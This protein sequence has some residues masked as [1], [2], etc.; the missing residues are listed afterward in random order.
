V[1]SLETF[2]Y[3]ALDALPSH[4]AILD[5][6]GNIVAVNEAW[7]TFASR[8]GART[9]VSEG[10]NYLEIC[11]QAHGRDADYAHQFAAGL[12]AVIQGQ[13]ETYS[14]EYPCH[15]PAE[16]RWFIARVSRFGGDSILVTHDL[17]TE[18]KEAEEKLNR[19]QKITASLSR[20]VTLDEV[21]A[22]VIEEGLASMNA[23]SGALTLLDEDGTTLRVMNSYKVPQAL[24]ERFPSIHLDERFFLA[25]AV[26]NQESI[27]IHDIEQIKNE[28][29]VSYD[30]ARSQGGNALAAL[31]LVVEGRV[32]GG[33]VVAFRKIQA[34]TQEDRGY[35][36]AMTDQCAQAIARA[37]LYDDGQRIRKA[38][39]TRVYQQSLISELGLHALRT[40]S[41][42]LMQ[43]TAERVAKGLEVEYVKVLELLPD[44]E[45]MTLSAG[46]GWEAGLVGNV[47]ESAGVHSQ[48]GYAL[49]TQQPVIVED[50][51][52]ETRFVSHSLLHNHGV[53]SGM[54]AIIQSTER[55]FGVLGAHTRHR[56]SFTQ[57]DIYFLQAMA[58]VLGAA[59][60]RERLYEQGQQ[61][62]RVLQTRVYQQSLI[63]ELG[64]HALRTDSKT[65]MQET[66]ERVAKGLEVEY[67]KVLELLPDGE[68]MTLSAGVG[69]EAGL[70]GNVTESAGVHSQAGY[71][72]LTQ[73]PV[74]V[75]DLTTETRF[76]SHSLLHN[77][78]VISGMSAI[79]QST[80]RPFG[81]LGAHTRHRRSFTQ[82]DIYFLQAMANV[83]GAAMERERLY[84]Q[85]R[86]AAAFEERQRLARDLHD[87]VS[88]T[89]FAATTTAEALPILWERGSDKAITRLH[90]VI[91][92]NRAAMAEM[93]NL[94]IE[95]RPDAIIKTQLGTL[96]RQLVDAARGRR[97]IQVEYL[98]EGDTIPFEMNP[99]AQIVFY[100]VAQEA[101]NNALKHSEAKSIRLCFDA[102]PDRLLL[103]VQDDGK[104]FDLSQ[105]GAGMGMG[106][107]R[108]RA[109]SIGAALRVESKIGRG[110]EIV[111]EWQHENLSV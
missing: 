105:D 56:R 40:D 78:G 111:L 14:L 37:R 54:S 10:V 82:D 35:L 97:H 50:L 96:F 89:L 83:L 44:G 80:E 42:T 73:Q 109:E 57:D 92:F 46:V 87:A 22:V 21:I 3:H 18:R 36:L 6:E 91:L 7:R 102:Q 29:P 25:D 47:T 103:R 58:N 27:W 66:A 17:I 85:I 65:L 71:A 104:G 98:T 94:L 1:T 72:L 63:S 34:F 70:V 95:L 110:T 60:E 101:M 81:V 99:D 74:I 79:I 15:S 75:E 76:V 20:A 39:Q 11:D 43:E 4:I 13:Q 64:L 5:R 48:A 2:A 108:E 77:H 23:L 88:Q 33:L 28:Y 86:N 53:I 45:R 67:V 62:Q 51:T 100:R 90:D 107:M 8:N 68:R 41:K 9:N 31:P 26:R 19:L 69:W 12:R 16:H 52:T 32:S 38:L 106:T 30:F 49:L 93:R 84:E 59:M 24:L 61:F 55:P